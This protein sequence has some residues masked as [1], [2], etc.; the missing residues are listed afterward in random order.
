MSSFSCPSL[1]RSTSS[2]RWSLK[3]CSTFLAFFTHDTGIRFLMYSSYLVSFALRLSTIAV[4]FLSLAF[5][6]VDVPMKGETA[7]KQVYSRS[8]V[9]L[10][11][12]LILAGEI[13]VVHFVSELHRTH[14]TG[15]REMTFWLYV[16]RK[17]R[18]CDRDSNDV[19]DL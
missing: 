9:T 1:R 5:F 19:I 10:L 11:H 14:S 17:W 16:I 2:S 18:M 8:R 7:R 6:V 13:R 3:R 15:G 12:I 4:P